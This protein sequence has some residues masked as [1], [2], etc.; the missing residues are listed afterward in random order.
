MLKAITALTLLGAGH[1]DAVSGPGVRGFE[2]LPLLCRSQARTG[3][4][5]RKGR[6]EFLA[7]WRSLQA[8]RDAEA[9]LPIPRRLR[10]SNVASSIIPK[11]RSTPKLLRSASRSA[12]AAARRPGDLAPR[13][14]RDGRSGAF[15][16]VLCPA[17]LLAG[18]RQDRLLLV[19]LG[20]DLEFESRPGTAAWRLRVS[21]EW[22][23]LWSS[24][25]P[26]YGGCGTAAA[27]YR[28]ELENSGPSRSCS[29]ARR[30]SVK[31]K[32]LQPEYR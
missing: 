10:L 13:R 1:A 22:E 16:A 5:D 21:K 17:V 27:R 24:D 15:A 3:E 29:A 14:G 23:K 2:P 28:G 20:V 9:A 26:Q 8:A 19:N 31:P 4:T 18:Y 7:Q 25:D 6:I 30:R 11:W 12:A 32:K